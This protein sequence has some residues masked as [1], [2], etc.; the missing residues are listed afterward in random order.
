MN[1]IESPIPCSICS[2]D[3]LKLQLLRP[4]ESFCCFARDIEAL[5]P[6]LCS[7]LCNIRCPFM[8][9]RKL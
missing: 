6:V 7:E 5:L 2:R 9:K 8:N 4:L 3:L 1:S